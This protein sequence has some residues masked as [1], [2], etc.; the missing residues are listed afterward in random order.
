M[1][2][3]D[4]ALT[5]PERGFE[6]TRSLFA[7]F[8]RGAVWGGNDLNTDSPGF[9]RDCRYLHELLTGRMSYNE[10]YMRHEDLAEMP[11]MLEYLVENGALPGTVL[12]EEVTVVVAV[13]A[14]GPRFLAIQSNGEYADDDSTEDFDWNTLEEEEPLYD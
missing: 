8:Y 1:I 14:S 10:F 13:N 4:A 7:N 9:L 2:R 11:R 12:P 5:G 6:R 3:N